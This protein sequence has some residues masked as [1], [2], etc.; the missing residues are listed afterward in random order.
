MADFNILA[1]SIFTKGI[2]PFLLVFTLIFAVLEKSKI[3]GDGKKQVNA[4]VALVV[5]LLVVAFAYPTGVITKLV[6]FMAVAAVIILIFLLLYG[7]V[8]SDKDGLKIPKGLQVTFAIIIGVALVVAV[9]WATGALGLLSGWFYGQS[10]STSLW[11]N[12]LLVIAVI[13]MMILA[14][15]SGG[16]SS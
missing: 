1:S 9:L 7:F 16:K 12:V 3:L 8:A 10:Y 13:V 11:A 4:I 6:P 5:G 15:T 2:L 14:L